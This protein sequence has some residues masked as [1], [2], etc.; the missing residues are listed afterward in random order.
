MASDLQRIIKADTSIKFGIRQNFRLFENCKANPSGYGTRLETKKRAQ[1]V[2]CCFN[3]IIGLSTK[4]EEH[5]I[6]TIL[7]VGKTLVDRDPLL[8]FFFF[9]F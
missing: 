2:N 8:L 7:K 5:E 1:K 9:F 6:A 3:H 4:G